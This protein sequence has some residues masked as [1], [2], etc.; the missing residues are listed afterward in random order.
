MF[1]VEEHEFFSRVEFSDDCWEWVGNIG[2]KGY[3]DFYI[4]R[5]RK[6][7]RAHRWSVEYFQGSIPGD[8]EVCHHCDNRKCVNP[9]HLFIGTRK[10]NMRDMVDKGRHHYQKQTHCNRGI[11]GLMKAPI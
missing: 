4:H 6:N 1:S 7:V 11:Y 9:F 5:L 2:S 8:K 10:D 3:G